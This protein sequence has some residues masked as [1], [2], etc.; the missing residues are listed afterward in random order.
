VIKNNIVEKNAGKNPSRANTPT[1]LPVIPP[2]IAPRKTAVIPP[3]SK[4]TTISNIA[5]MNLFQNPA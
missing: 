4:T 3:I 2:K 5:A 1:T